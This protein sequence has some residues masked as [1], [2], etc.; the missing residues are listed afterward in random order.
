MLDLFYVSTLAPWPLPVKG[1]CLGYDS[2]A[3]AKRVL[4]SWGLKTPF[5]ALTSTC[6]VSFASEVVRVRKVRRDANVLEEIH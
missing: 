5:I 1:V 3:S 6:Y 4:R 2:A